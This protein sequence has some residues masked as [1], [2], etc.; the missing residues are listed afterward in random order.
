M[1][2]LNSIWMIALAPITV[3]FSA[4]AE[5]RISCS[6][7]WQIVDGRHIASPFCGDEHLAKVARQY[8]M[9]VSGRA[10]RRSFAMKQETCQLVGHDNR[11]REICTGFRNDY[12][13]DRGGSRR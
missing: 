3:A 10:L 1:R 6:G 5:A 8:G 2:R 11:V 9:H 4:P 12:D 7:P 13:G